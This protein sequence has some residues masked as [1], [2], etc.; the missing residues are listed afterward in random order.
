MS[1]RKHA[2]GMEKIMILFIVH[3]MPTL[4]LEKIIKTF[5][6]VTT[7]MPS[8]LNTFS[9]KRRSPNGKKHWYNSQQST[10]QYQKDITTSI[11]AFVDQTRQIATLLASPSNPQKESEEREGEIVMEQQQEEVETYKEEESCTEDS[12]LDGGSA[13]R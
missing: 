7:I 6:G 2:S 3:I 9:L 4:R 13:I 11:Q 5:L 8:S 12:K 1:Q 10:A